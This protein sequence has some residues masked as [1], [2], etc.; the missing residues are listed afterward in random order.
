MIPCIEIVGTR[1]CVH[2]LVGMTPI[3]VELTVLMVSSKMEMLDLSTFN[4]YPSYKGQTG[5][6]TQAYYYYE[7]LHEVRFWCKWISIGAITSSS[8]GM[9]SITRPH[10]IQIQIIFE[11]SPIN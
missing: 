6:I 10:N 9:I 2:F 3:E 1:F 4:S 5:Y 11:L 7:V 8:C